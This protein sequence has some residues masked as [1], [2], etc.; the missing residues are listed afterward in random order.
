M[1][2]IVGLGNPGEKYLNTRHN[3][4]FITVDEITY[5]EKISFKREKIFEANIASFFVESEKIYLIKPTT[6][7]NESGRAVKLLLTYF[8]ISLDNLVVIYD[9]LDMDVGRVRLRMKGSAGGHNGVKSLIYHLDTRK[10]NRVKIGIGHPGRD[11]SVVDYVLAT[12][13]KEEKE[14]MAN[15]L[16]TTINAIDYFIQGHSFMETMNQ[17][18]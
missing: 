1:K 2:M 9:D 18:N 3:V 17:F 12:F 6:F 14:L 10:F 5:R 8:N 13:L 11:H 16:K 4:G 7:M 15:A